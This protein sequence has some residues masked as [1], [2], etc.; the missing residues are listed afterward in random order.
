M[1]LSAFRPAPRSHTILYYQ[2]LQ[3]ASAPPP[4]SIDNM[5]HASFAFVQEPSFVLK[6][7]AK[8][9]AASEKQHTAADEKAWLAQ[10]DAGRDQSQESLPTYQDDATTAPRSVLPFC[11]SSRLDKSA[12]SLLAQESLVPHRSSTGSG[13]ERRP[14]ALSPKAEEVGF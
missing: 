11:R 6:Q 1:F 5:N 4:S 9:A 2:S 13:V 14:R 12:N 8:K 3:Q 10:V 7:K